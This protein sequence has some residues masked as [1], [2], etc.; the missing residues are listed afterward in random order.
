M[1]VTKPI[2]EMPTVPFPPGTVTMKMKIVLRP[3]HALSLFGSF[4]DYIK[5]LTPTITLM[6]IQRRKLKTTAHLSPRHQILFNS[7]RS[8]RSFQSIVRK[9]S[10]KCVFFFSFLCLCFDIVVFFYNSRTLDVYKSCTVY[11]EYFIKF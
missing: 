8:R 1:R 9:S 2:F 11:A 10:I 4:I 3:E 6:G 7:H 5:L